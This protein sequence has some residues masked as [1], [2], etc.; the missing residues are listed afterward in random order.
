MK[1]KKETK[2]RELTPGE[3]AWNVVSA[4]LAVIIPPIGIPLCILNAILSHKKEKAARNEAIR[5]ESE[6]VR[7]VSPAQEAKP[8]HGHTPVE[9]SYDTCAATRRLEQLNVL[10]KAG[11]YTK[12]QYLEAKA[13]IAKA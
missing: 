12:E 10:Y 8:V 7:R 2:K 11:L 9:Y 4:I 3:K 13:K 1:A 6:I 5:S